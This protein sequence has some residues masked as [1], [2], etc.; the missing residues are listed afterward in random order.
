ML[1]LLFLGIATGISAIGCCV[2]NKKAKDYSYKIDEQGRPTWI[3]RKGDQYINGEKT[4]W[5]YGYK[6][7]KSVKVGV[8]TGK[9]YCDPEENQ[10]RIFR[11][12][13]ERN[14]EHCMKWGY[15]SYEKYVPELNKFVSCEMSTGKFIAKLDRKIENGKPVYRKYYLDIDAIKPKNPI[16]Y[17]P[18]TC[19]PT[20]PIWE[21]MPG[22]EGIVISEEEFKSL[23]Y[24]GG[25]H[26]GTHIKV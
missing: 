26:M 24:W 17:I 3:D 9:V 13:S 23:N 15:T 6:N 5:K 21:S 22:D 4:V 18:Y 14:R 19:E 8:V 2:D 11:E 12:D 16:S 10:L 1:G 25:T 7:N 20:Q